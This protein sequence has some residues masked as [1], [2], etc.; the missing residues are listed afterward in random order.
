MDKFEKRLQQYPKELHNWLCR[1][2]SCNHLARQPFKTD[3]DGKSIKK[4]LKDQR[5][6]T[7]KERIDALHSVARLF[8][9]TNDSKKEF[10]NKFKSFLPRLL[11]HLKDPHSLVVRASCVSL[12]KIMM[13]KN[14][15]MTKY[16]QKIMDALTKNFQKTDKMISESSYGCFANL[17]RH[18]PDNKK[19]ATLQHILK[20]VNTK[21]VPVRCMGWRIAAITFTRILGLKKARPSTWWSI[22]ENIL[23]TGKKEKSKEVQRWAIRLLFIFR[24]SQKH[25]HYV[26]QYI[27]FFPNP[28]DMDKVK[29]EA[30][31]EIQKKMDEYAEEAAAQADALEV[32]S[33][34]STEQDPQE[35]ESKMNGP[36]SSVGGGSA[37]SRG[38]FDFVDDIMEGKEIKDP[39]ANKGLGKRLVLHRINRDTVKDVY[40]LYDIGNQIENTRTLLAS[41]KYL[42]INIQRGELILLITE[43]KM[44]VLT[45]NDQ[46]T[47][48]KYAFFVKHCFATLDVA[49]KT[50]LQAKDNLLENMEDEYANI[51]NPKERFE[52]KLEVLK[53]LCT[54]KDD[55]KQQDLTKKCEVLQNDI[56]GVFVTPE[57]ENDD[58]IFEEMMEKLNP[59]LINEIINGMANPL[60]MQEICIFLSRIAQYHTARFA[61]YGN[62]YYDKFFQLIG[63][64]NN[65]IIHAC[66]KTCLVIASMVQFLN[67]PTC[68]AMTT[69][70]IKA[71]TV[72]ENSS[73][74]SETSKKHWDCQVI[75]Y[76]C[77]LASV[78]TNVPQ[79][80]NEYA[81]QE[82][83]DKLWSIMRN[84]V[85]ANASRG[86]HEAEG[87]KMICL[88]ILGYMHGA[89][90][91]NLKQ[92][93]AKEL[94]ESTWAAVEG[95]TESKTW[96]TVLRED[97]DANETA[98]FNNLALEHG[99]DNLQYYSQDF[100][101]R[102]ILLE[103]WYELEQKSNNPIGMA[104]VTQ[105]IKAL[106]HTQYKAKK[107]QI[108]PDD[109]DP[110]NDVSN[111]TGIVEAQ[112]K[113]RE[114]QAAIQPV[115]PMPTGPQQTT[116]GNGNANASSAPVHDASGGGDDLAALRAQFLARQREQ[117]Q[118]QVQ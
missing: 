72:T 34:I 52:E 81:K 60:W 83:I 42:G 5:K 13:Y 49:W 31:D 11:D 37:G 45:G 14:G 54:D 43:M 91:L 55:M 19:F 50:Y 4:I 15:S 12:T 93:E 69:S 29:A 21:S 1:I 32:Y 95:I 88:N 62:Q 8:A 103:Q 24:N 87:V 18:V 64:G 114:S 59:V 7:W 111:L 2:V 51:S 109:Y 61:E 36:G 80:K 70:L 77:L 25:Y 99:W 41:L 90:Y 104:A 22:A 73:K 26:D 28:P 110:N 57:V 10:Q 65:I 17:V 108:K 27:R 105:L 9:R 79:I 56:Y 100:N 58:V 63:F 35:D 67:S 78:M 94:N 44:R 116:N 84:K 101:D 89:K 66:S 16:T 40:E 102:N 85:Y 115:S 92:R 71:T 113:R 39:L 76:K 53:N 98:P 33:L 47:L 48:D 112:K 117:N 118:Y 96:N 86:G 23:K 30:L 6:L 46:F 74:S 38:A 75:I 82:V 68:E 3:P 97:I 106:N 107:T 20:L